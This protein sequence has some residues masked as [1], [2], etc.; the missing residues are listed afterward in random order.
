MGDP[1][2][3]AS[4]LVLSRHWH[5]TNS[6]IS[7]VIRSLA[8]AAS[9]LGRITVCTP[10]APGPASP[11]GGFDVIAI[12]KGTTTPWPAPEAVAWPVAAEPFSVIIVDEMDDSCRAILRHHC[13]NLGVYDVADRSEHAGGAPDVTEGPAPVRMPPTIGIHVPVSPLARLHRH[14][15]LGFT[16]YLLVL[17]DRVGQADAD[18]PSPMA[19]WLTARYF[20]AYVVVIEDASA[21]V[22]KGRSLRGRISV[23]T[24]TDLQRLIAHARILIDLAPGTVVARECIESLRLGTPILVPEGSAADVHA[25]IGGMSFADIPDCLAQAKRLMADDLLRSVSAAGQAY[26]DATFGRS[27]HAISSLR[28]FLTRAP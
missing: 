17:S 22:W 9:R 11:D 26:A 14:T 15:G 23:E 19:A 10:G 27:E 7:F 18:A 16:G 21:S 8:G 4:K 2:P 3:P 12:G 6:E 25:R 20:D 1:S 24:R 28:E 13:A 5:D